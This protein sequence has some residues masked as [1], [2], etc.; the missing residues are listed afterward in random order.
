MAMYRSGAFRLAIFR[1]WDL[2]SRITNHFYKLDCWWSESAAPRFWMVYGKKE[3]N[4]LKKII[5]SR[6]A[7]GCV[8]LIS[9]LPSN[10]SRER[11]FTDSKQR[12]SKAILF[13]W[14]VFLCS[15]AHFTPPLDVLPSEGFI[16]SSA[17]IADICVRVSSNEKFLVL[18]DNWETEFVV[19]SSL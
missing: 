8:C 15:W 10:L 6:P 17:S 12:R 14:I 2:L 19:S 9:R 16:Y 13:L 18:R 5:S 3:R 4:Q 11:A 7:C 1:R